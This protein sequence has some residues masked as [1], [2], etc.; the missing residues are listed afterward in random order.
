VCGATL[1]QANRIVN[2]WQLARAYLQLTRLS[3]LPAVGSS[4]F[5]LIPSKEKDHKKPGPKE[6]FPHAH[7]LVAHLGEVRHVF[8]WGC[9]FCGFRA[10]KLQPPNNPQQAT[11]TALTS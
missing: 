6:T 2:N 1:C 10:A 7:K 9:V 8:G 11:K 5:I 4:F 3:P